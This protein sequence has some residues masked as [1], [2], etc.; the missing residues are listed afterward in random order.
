M[1]A[2]QIAGL[3]LVILGACW[4][5]RHIWRLWQAESEALIRRAYEAANVE[6][7][8]VVDLVPLLPGEATDDEFEA[9]VW[10]A[11]QPIREDRREAFER[12]AD[13]IRNLPE[14]TSW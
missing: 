4:L 1:D 11:L 6:F 13:E 5:A 14:V 8:E 3:A 7:D 2:D 10:Q 12:T 9:W